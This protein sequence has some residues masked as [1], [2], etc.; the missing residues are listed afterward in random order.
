[1]NDMND[2][3]RAAGA[4]AVR[5][6]VHGAVDPDDVQP[7]TSGSKGEVPL[8]TVGSKDWVPPYPLPDAL[9]P[10]LPFDLDLLPDSVRG[11]V[12]DIVHR[13]QCP[14][15]F[16]VATLIVVLSILIGRRVGVRPKAFDNWTVIPNL[17]ACIIGRPGAMKSPAMSAVLV[18]LHRL[19]A[20]AAKVHEEAYA[21]YAAEARLHAVR[22]SAFEKR[23][24]QAF[25]QDPLATLEMELPEAPAEPAQRRFLVND[26][27][28]EALAEILRKNP[29][30]LGVFR[31][32]LVSLIASL[33]REGQEGARGFYLTA[34]NGDDSY[35]VD[36]IGRGLYLRIEAL[37][38]SVLGGTQPGRWTDYLRQAVKGGAADDGLVQRFSVLV[39]PDVSPDWKDVDC[40]PDGEA[41]QR[42]WDLCMA[43]AHADPVRDWGAQI[44]PYA[45][46]PFLRFGPAALDLFR[47]W[48]EGLERRVRSSELHPALESHLSKYRKLVPAL[49]L[50]LHLADGGVGDIG[51]AAMLRALGWAR[52][53]ESHARRAYAAV[54]QPETEGARALLRRI[55]KGEVSDGFTLRSVYTK[56]W[57][58][59][60]TP[61]A[62][63]HAA[64]M[65]VEYG[66]LRRERR[67][68]DGRP[69]FMY[70]INPLGA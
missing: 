9:P 44:D 70:H 25:K 61:E 54:A 14:V 34:W 56:G 21:Q 68:T 11:F 57:T 7:E 33:E 58:H 42:V 27:T 63:Q 23:A 4:E 66:W 5:A 30:G 51:E 50:I 29:Q 41:K 62:A 65:L 32:E 26:S 20:E 28:V 64:D 59:L 46:V 1:M 53:L 39:W 38:L 15:D 55:R 3:Y 37:C 18:F 24:A 43:L 45:A 17:W 12:E 8:G 6:A 36:R 16:V 2:L 47:S 49:A 10:V 52:Y 31:D 67:D 60:N 19:D 35:I 13:S 69:T 48:R 40:Y 22:V